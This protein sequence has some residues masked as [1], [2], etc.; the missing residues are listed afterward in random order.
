MN[1]RFILG[2]DSWSGTGCSGKYAHV[3]E[4]IEEK[5]VNVTGFTSN[6]GSIYNLSIFNV[7]YTFDKEDRTVFLLEHNNT[8]YMGYDMIYSLARPIQCKYNDVRVN[9][10]PKVSYPNNNNS[11]SIIFPYGT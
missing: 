10:L 5:S 4:F 6:L 11:Q 9:L 8:I 2:L 1:S 7:F 3:N